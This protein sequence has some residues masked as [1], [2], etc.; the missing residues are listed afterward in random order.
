MDVPSPDAVV[1]S[2]AGQI[3]RTAQTIRDTV[4]IEP[5]WLVETE[6]DCYVP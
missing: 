4:P 3:G 2:G 5:D 1:D 6:A